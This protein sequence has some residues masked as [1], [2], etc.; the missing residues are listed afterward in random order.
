MGNR[1]KS[2][3]TVSRPKRGAP[4]RRPSLP[5]ML[6][7]MSTRECARRAAH[8]G[9][10]KHALVRLRAELHAIDAAADVAVVRVRDANGERAALG[11]DD[12]PTVPPGFDPLPTVITPPPL[13]PDAVDQLLTLP[14]PA[15]ARQSIPRIRHAQGQPLPL[16][17]P[18]QKLT[19][20]ATQLD[21]QAQAQ[22]QVQVQH[23]LVETPL[24]PA[25]KAGVLARELDVILANAPDLSLPAARVRTRARASSQQSVGA[26]AP[27]SKSTST[28]NPAKAAATSA[29][30][31]ASL[32]SGS[33]ARAAAARVVASK[34]RPLGGGGSALA[35][36][37]AS[38][39]ALNQAQP[40]PQS[41]FGTTG[42]TASF[43]RNG[44]TLSFEQ[45]ANAATSC[46]NATAH[47]HVFRTQAPAPAPATH[48]PRS[49]YTHTNSQTRQHTRARPQVAH[50]TPLA[51]RNVRAPPSRRQSLGSCTSASGGTHGGGSGTAVPTTMVIG[52][53]ELSSLR[54]G[55]CGP[56]GTGVGASVSTNDSGSGSGSTHGLALAQIRRNTTQ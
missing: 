35:D 52:A 53:T 2:S 11:I 5:Q 37:L 49:T 15:S 55:W 45:W 50:R 41:P 38:A 26:Q 8:A 31:K 4:P 42:S 1:R 19:A 22:V 16:Q 51:Q 24:S 14:A 12:A 28:S 13:L 36:A 43:Q 6:A 25:H 54:A 56:S 44:T 34:R 9:K 30:T 47:G 23:V 29:V 10:L 7:R 33:A 21:E 3:A 48:A 39:S 27:T 40:Q 17:T 32:M 46:G 18:L 20:A